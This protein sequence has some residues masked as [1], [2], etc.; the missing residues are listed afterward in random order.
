MSAMTPADA[1]WRW[2]TTL[3]PCRIPHE[4]LYN[5]CLPENSGGWLSCVTCGLRQ[6]PELTTRTRTGDRP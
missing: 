2:L 3:A 4:D 6:R 1:I 5:P